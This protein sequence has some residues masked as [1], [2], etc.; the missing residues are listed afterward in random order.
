MP[1]PVFL[2]VAAL[3]YLLCFINDKHLVIKAHLYFTCHSAAL[4]LAAIEAKKIA[5]KREQ[6][7][8][9][10]RAKMK[11]DAMRI[12]TAQKHSTLSNQVQID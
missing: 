5:P 9:L 2:K 11:H 6:T 8:Y 3:C 12:V 10:E 7:C 1:Q 4:N